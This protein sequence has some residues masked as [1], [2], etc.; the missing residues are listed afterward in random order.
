MLNIPYDVEKLIYR[1][2]HEMNML[3]VMSQIK[4]EVCELNNI[5]YYLQ[6]RVFYPYSICLK[7]FKKDYFNETSLYCRNKIYRHVHH[8][9]FSQCLKYIN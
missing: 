1:N 5:I 4:K 6:K 2:V 9:L 8:K 3:E 7:I